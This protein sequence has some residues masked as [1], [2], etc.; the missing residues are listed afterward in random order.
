MPAQN[1]LS[2]VDGKAT[3]LTHVFTVMGAVSNAGEIIGSWI[4]RTASVLTGGAEQVKSYFKMKADGG[5][6]IRVATVLP[7]TEV[8]AGVSVVTRVLKATTT[9]ELPANCSPAE[10]KDL[11]VLH[12]NVIT[13]T[14]MM[15]PMV[16]NAEPSF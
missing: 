12:V 6:S 7:I 1:T 13:N 2:V 5:C 10:R 11:R 3:P 14:V 16:D 4:N 8:V 9:Y 15:V